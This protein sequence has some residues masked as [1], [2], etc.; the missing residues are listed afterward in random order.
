MGSFIGSFWW[1]NINDQQILP[2]TLGSQEYPYFE[3]PRLGV[4]RVPIVHLCLA[5]RESLRMRRDRP[6]SKE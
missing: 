5:F 3:D 4:Y 1:Q 2:K 6:G